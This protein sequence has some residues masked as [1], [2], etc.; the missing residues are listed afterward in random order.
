M[1]EAADRERWDAIEKVLDGALDLPPDM[2]PEFLAEA[3]AGD[4]ALRAEVE[5]LLR[6]HDAAGDYLEVPVASLESALAGVYGPGRQLGPYRLLRELGRGG[7][8]L[9]YLASDTRLDRQVALKVLPASRTADPRARA[10]FQREARAASALD[11]PNICTVYEMGES[12]A[13]DPY[14]AMAYVQGE[15][16]R[17]RIAR[18]PLPLSDAID[19]TIQTARGLAHAHR[20]GIVHRD[21]KPANLIVTPEGRVKIVDFGLA[22]GHGDPTL[23]RQGITPGT[24]AYMSPEQLT[25][26]AVDHRTDIWAL[27]VVL[28]EMITGQPPFRGDDERSRSYAILNQDPEPL[29]ALRAGIPLSLDAIL[30]KVLSKDPEARFQH[31]DELPVDLGGALEGSKKGIPGLAGPRPGWKVGKG[32][33]LVL[34][35]VALGVLVASMSLGRGSEPEPHPSMHLSVTLPPDQELLGTL[36]RRFALSPDGRQLVYAARRQGRNQL[37]LRPLDR[38]ESSPIPG[39]E[40]GRDPFFSPDGR[41]VGFFAD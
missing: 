25:G 40:N 28:Y 22:K 37:F 32:L 31:V 2:R 3:C 21:V 13:G 11:H 10:R 24:V 12:V 39:T 29:T 4:E 35:G 9:V 36:F 1:P 6:A 16:L 38:D 17:A 27:G 7:L 23:T 34:S 8:G 15:S 5:S 20:H 18:G 41:W 19:F 14:I 33:G 30:S 26:R